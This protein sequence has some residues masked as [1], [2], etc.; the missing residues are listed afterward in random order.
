MVAYVKRQQT[1]GYCI[2]LE[3]HS[4]KDRKTVQLM[5]LFGLANIWL[6]RKA[7]LAAS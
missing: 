2:R 4:A 7:L 5:T 6:A 1:F 3:F